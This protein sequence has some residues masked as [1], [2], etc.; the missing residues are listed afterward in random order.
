MNLKSILSAFLLLLFAAFLGAKEETIGD[1]WDGAADLPVPLHVRIPEKPCAEPMPALVICPGGGYAM[2]CIEPEGFGIAEWLNRNGIAGFV[3]EYRL[4]K[5]NK[6]VPLSDAQ[7]AIAWVRA[8]AEEY[9]VD[10]QKIGIIGFSAGG[11][12]AS[13]AA[14]HFGFGDP[15]SEDPIDAVSYRPD[16]AVLIYPVITM[17]SGLTHEGTRRELLGDS[18]SETDIDFF[19]SEKQITP[20]TPPVFLAHAQDDT[21]VPPENSQM[22]ADRMKELG[23]PCVYLKLESGGHGLNGYQGE[24]W[25]K[26]QSEA[27]DWIKQL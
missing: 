8:H 27:I 7:R 26:W 12:L 22:F 17:Q 18:P 14:V 10:P 21:V 20:Q 25:D 23:R 6:E 16:F 11:H 5:G 13:S 15:E 3:L 4:P 1:I 2:R 9:G 24:S 19:S